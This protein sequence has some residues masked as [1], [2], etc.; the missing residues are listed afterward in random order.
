MTTPDLLPCILDV[1][2]VLSDRYPLEFRAGFR[3]LVSLL[4]G[5]HLDVQMSK[6]MGVI[7][8]QGLQRLWRAWR[9]CAAFG[10]GVLRDLR[11]DLEMAFAAEAAPASAGPGLPRVSVGLLGVLRCVLAVARALG[12][13]LLEGLNPEMGEVAVEEGEEGVVR[14]EY[15]AICE[16]LLDIVANVGIE[17][18]GDRVWRSMGVDFVKFLSEAR[19]GVEMVPMQAVSVRILGIEVE[20]FYHEPLEVRDADALKFTDAWLHNLDE[21]LSNW[22]GSLD[23]QLLVFFVSP[24]ASPVLSKLRSICGRDKAAMQGLLKSCKSWVNQIHRAQKGSMYTVESLQSILLEVVDAV[25]DLKLRRKI[26]PP[27]VDRKV[28]LAHVGWS[29]PQRDLQKYENYVSE[30]KNTEAAAVMKAIL[31]FDIG[32]LIYCATLG[33]PGFDDAV[34]VH[35]LKTVLLAPVGAEYLGYDWWIKLET[36]MFLVVR[37]VDVKTH[38][39]APKSAGRYVTELILNVVKRL[40]ARFS[41][42]PHFLLGAVW[43]KDIVRVLKKE[44]SAANDVL[45]KLQEIVFQLIPRLDTEHDHEIR[46][47]IGELLVE[48]SPLLDLSSRSIEFYFP[49]FRRLKDVY[50]DVQS[51]FATCIISLSSALVKC[52]AQ[53][54]S[55]LSVSD[56]FKLSVMA[57]PNLGSFRW[58]HFEIAMRSLAI[59]PRAIDSKPGDAQILMRLFHLSQSSFVVNNSANLMVASGLL[60][61]LQQCTCLTSF[62]TELQAC[63]TAYLSED[64]LV[65]WALWECARFCVLSRLRT[66]FGN[67]EQTFGAFEDGLSGKKSKGLQNCVIFIELL[68]LQIHNA[69]SGSALNIPTAPKSSVSF[70]YANKSVCDE[71]FDRVR[72]KI[73]NAYA[74]LGDH[75]AGCIFHAG[76]EIQRL[77]RGGDRELASGEQFR[78]ALSSLSATFVASENLDGLLGI[79]G[80]A[81]ELNLENEQLSNVQALEKAVA[82]QF[83]DG[84]SELWN[85]LENPHKVLVDAILHAQAVR[86][87]WTSLQSLGAD[88]D[89]LNKLQQWTSF[90]SMVPENTK[91]AAI[92]SLLSIACQTDTLHCVTELRKASDR[93]LVLKKLPEFINSIQTNIA[94]SISIDSQLEPAADIPRHLAYIEV[95]NLIKSVLNSTLS[96]SAFKRFLEN[97]DTLP[98]QS[99]PLVANLANAFDL[100]NISLRKGLRKNGFLIRRHD[101]MESCSMPSIINLDGLENAKLEFERTQDLSQLIRLATAKHHSY[102]EQCIVSKAAVSCLKRLSVLERDNNTVAL[103]AASESLASLQPGFDNAF[104]ILFNFGKISAPSHAKVWLMSADFAF[105]KASSLIDE[106]RS[107]SFNILAPEFNEII[108]ILPQSSSLEV[109]SQKLC[110]LFLLELEDVPTEKN[111]SYM[112][113][114]L[115]SSLKSEFPLLPA[116]LVS[117]LHQKLESIKSRIISLFGRAAHEYLQFLTLINDSGAMNNRVMAVMLRLLKLMTILS[118]DPNIAFVEGFTGGPVTP[119]HAVIPQLFSCLMHSS[120]LVRS[121]AKDLLC[122]IGA[123][124]PKTLVYHCAV[125]RASLKTQKS[126][127][128][129]ILL[130]QIQ[131]SIG[132]DV[133][134]HVSELLNELQ[135]VTVLW[136]E[137]WFNKLSALNGEAPK[138]L[139]QFASEF[140]RMETAAAKATLTL[141]EKYDLIMF[142]VIHSISKLVQETIDR[143]PATAHETWFREMYHERIHVALHHL[144][145]PKDLSALKGLWEPF[146]QITNDISKDF[147]R[148]R[149]LR[150]FDLSPKLQTLASLS[151]PMPVTK[152]N[153]AESQIQSFDESVLVLPT[154]TKPKK[155]VLIAENGDS[156]PFLFKGLEDLHLDERVQQ[157][158]QVANALLK[159]DKISRQKK[160]EARTYGVIPL[161]DQF[162]MIQWVDGVTS[163]F[164]IYKRWQLR[165]NA[166]RSCVNAKDSSDVILRP[167]EQYHAKVSVALKKAGISRA[168]SRRD[169]P[170]SILRG[171]FNELLSETPSDLIQND[172]RASSPLL[173][174]WWEKICQFSRSYGVNAILGYILGLGD[175]HLDNILID[176]KSGSVLHIDYNVCFDKG[177]RLRVPETV[178]FRLTQNI[179]SALGPTGVQGAFKS[180]CT[181]TLRVLQENSDVFMSLLES[182]A[183]DPLSDWVADDSETEERLTQLNMSMKLLASRIAENRVVLLESARTLAVDVST[184]VASINEFATLQKKRNVV[185]LEV[186]ALTEEFESLGFTSPSKVIELEEITLRDEVNACISDSKIWISRHQMALGNIMHPFLNGMIQAVSTQP[187]FFREDTLVANNLDLELESL[188]IKSRVELNQLLQ[189]FK[190]YQSLISPVVNF[191][192]QQDLRLRLV[193]LLTQFQLNYDLDQTRSALLLEIQDSNGVVPQFKDLEISFDRKTKEVEHFRQHTSALV[194]SEAM[195]MRLLS[196]HDSLKRQHSQNTAIWSQIMCLAAVRGVSRFGEYLYHVERGNVVP[197]SAEIMGLAMSRKL[198]SASRSKYRFEPSNVELCVLAV[199]ASKSWFSTIHGALGTSASPEFGTTLIGPLTEVLSFCQ[200]LSQFSA[201]FSQAFLLVIALCRSEPTNAQSLKQELARLTLPFSMISDFRS[202]NYQLQSDKLRDDYEAMKASLSNLAVG[203]VTSAFENVFGPLEHQMLNLSAKDDEALRKKLFVDRIL[204]FQQVVEACQ[205]FVGKN[206]SESHVQFQTLLND[207]D[208]DRVCM[209]LNQFLSSVSREVILKLLLKV[210]SRVPRKIASDFVPSCAVAFRKALPSKTSGQNLKSVCNAFLVNGMKE[211]GI[212]EAVLE[213]VEESM[214]VICET[215]TSLLFAEQVQAHLTRLEWSLNEQAQALNRFQ[216]IHEQSLYKSCRIKNIRQE[217]ILEFVA[218]NKRCSAI[219]ELLRSFAKTVDELRISQKAPEALENHLAVARTEIGLITSMVNMSE[220]LVDLEMAR[221]PAPAFYDPI[222]RVLSILSSME[223][224]N[225]LLSR[226]IHR[227]TKILQARF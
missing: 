5:W 87:D 75:G 199:A 181:V 146:V 35:A 225:F 116:D 182:L 175:R 90:V 49:L 172:F 198:L 105:K 109:L 202:M 162:G 227:E 83:R 168:A 174:D 1:L 220:S 37:D 34:V 123:A 218:C 112:R 31:L 71:W 149:K 25:L 9:A 148:N 2:A 196:A 157:V 98:K 115:E 44:D 205:F 215:S 99:L 23:P 26:V 224:L 110:S 188:I 79:S 185:E 155:M 32:L 15:L 111:M 50:S 46:I 169:W 113:G 27:G 200:L 143:V 101:L 192:T 186:V 107:K 121:N 183:F 106:V 210:L 40:L 29:L 173:S 56:K 204:I 156:H 133:V 70:F 130:S 95:A 30:L 102:D 4:V 216:Y 54:N 203:N 126:I 166:A 135:R 73:L 217:V 65:F 3:D 13:A 17:F 52:R 119:W 48:S 89:S 222:Q 16:T 85:G 127:V 152:T 74:E 59:Y 41:V 86:N 8:S 128:L 82:G 117:V 108:S 43:L 136:E 93:P 139:N 125:S 76:K 178:P 62:P 94:G 201:Q 140:N 97:V 33:V 147:Q 129:Q 91:S 190:A 212:S 137:L 6:Q 184:T 36:A 161:G 223:K 154:K 211:T 21:V 187:T 63:G 177:L 19:L 141:R 72:P 176:S 39:V 61:G 226:H 55:K 165:D 131:S 191:M 164:S 171:V 153:M 221:V 11:G 138:R 160:L 84:F 145:S 28:L 47:L 68:E 64:L 69:I 195:N 10:C 193:S 80:M 67:P 189:R 77:V 124:S 100:S 180:T 88:S 159:S 163:L 144:K 214:W 151:L 12:F 120:G 114:N 92:G 194:D 81:D 219:N 7:V 158:L 51:V 42:Y 103:A 58:N 104:D 213:S 150:L 22:G 96:K 132:L 197:E 170:A 142:P 53:P 57:S 208:F 122:R 134:E 24:H 179:I 78:N 66:P 20:S 209:T 118:S 45:S 207:T 14:R 38:L 167:N 60:L 206:T 18:W